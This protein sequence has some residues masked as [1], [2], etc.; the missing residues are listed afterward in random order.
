LHVDSAYG[1]AALFSGRLSRLLV[2]ADRADSFALDFHKLGWAPASASAFLVRDEGHLS[3]LAADAAYL[4]TADDAA[5]GYTSSP[6]GSL[7]T[8]R[9]ADAMKIAVVL[10]VLGRQGLSAFVESCHDLAVHAAD[11]IAAQPG[12]ELAAAP[13]LSTVVFRC[14]PT[15]TGGLATDADALNATVRRLL[16]ER[17]ESLVGRTA[18]PGEAGRP[19]VHLKLVLMAPTTTPAQIDAVIERVAAT[20]RAV[21]AMGV[22][23]T[24][25]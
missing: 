10:G 11:R 15:G 22:A 8:T 5:A 1:G 4:G 7:Q 13:V 25:V 16:A 21:E 17:G 20:A 3:S 23:P 19:N 9:R 12:L 2:G 14:L 18:L 24:R 6:P